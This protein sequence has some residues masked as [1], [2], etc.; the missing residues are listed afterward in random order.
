MEDT[1]QHNKIELHYWY[2]DNS[3]MQE[4]NPKKFRWLTWMYITIAVILL[5][6]FI[7]N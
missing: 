1:Y 7:L 6:I 3:Q 5:L 2:K 4:V